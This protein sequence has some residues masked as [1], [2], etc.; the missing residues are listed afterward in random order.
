MARLVCAG[1]LSATEVSET[2]GAAIEA[3]GK[4]RAEGEKVAAWAVARR[5]DTG[6]VRR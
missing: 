6:E 4:A 3:A 5:A 1:R 2:I